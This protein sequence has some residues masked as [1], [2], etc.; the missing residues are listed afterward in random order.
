MKK[1]TKTT[2]LILSALMLFGCTSNSANGGVLHRRAKV[3]SRTAK[4]KVR[5]KARLLKT[6]QL[7]IIQ[8]IKAMKIL[9]KISMGIRRFRMIKTSM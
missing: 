8:M 2:A 9:L 4:T 5:L 7:R 1:L 3:R 6:A